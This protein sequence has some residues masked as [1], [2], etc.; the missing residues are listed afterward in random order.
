M[1]VMSSPG[2]SGVDET[3]NELIPAAIIFCKNRAIN[4]MPMGILTVADGGMGK[5]VDVTTKVTADDGK[6]IMARLLPIMVIYDA[7][8]D[9]P[10]D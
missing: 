10:T 6:M 8:L 4:H 5:W 9:D 1:Q 7:N 3:P 2:T